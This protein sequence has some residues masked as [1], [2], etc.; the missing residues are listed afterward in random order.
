MLQAELSKFFHSNVTRIP[1][2]NVSSSTLPPKSVVITTVELEKSLLDVITPNEIEHVKIMT[3][4]ASVLLWISGGNLLKAER[5]EFSLVPGLS[6][7]IMLEQPALKFCTFD[8]RNN[9][10]EFQAATVHALAILDQ[11][12]HSK[13][14]EYEYM[15][16]HNILYSSRLYPDEIANTAF[17]QKQGS[18]LQQLSLE[19]AGHCQLS[20]KQVGQLDSV[21]FIQ[22]PQKEDTMQPDYVEI[23]VKCIGL[24]AKV[25]TNFRS[26]DD[27]LVNALDRTSMFL[28]VELT[29]KI[30]HARSTSRV[31]YDG[32]GLL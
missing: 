10:S 15:Q 16:H 23:Q 9:A 13:S 11:A 27:T 21:H 22:L 20:V 25:R 26:Q 17:R 6:R 30:Q 8:I 12:L 5:P 4:S 14:P 18:S 3:D 2:S 1:L 24:N 19:N 7:S 28:A 32:S 31:S 29:P